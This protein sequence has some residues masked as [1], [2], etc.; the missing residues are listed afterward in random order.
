MLWFDPCFYDLISWIPLQSQEPKS[1]VS[2]LVPGLM[3][4]VYALGLENLLRSPL[5]TESST[6][7]I[8]F[9]VLNRSKHTVFSLQKSN[10]LVLEIRR[11]VKGS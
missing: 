5:H 10:Y 4:G 11:H 2:I 7:S 8:F 1:D 9:A 6:C 3:F